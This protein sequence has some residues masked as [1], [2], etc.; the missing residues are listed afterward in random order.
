MF[1]WK[2]IRAQAADGHLRVENAAKIG[3]ISVRFRD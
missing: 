3:A 1:A 2:K